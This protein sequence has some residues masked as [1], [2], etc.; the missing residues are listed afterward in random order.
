MVGALKEPF[1]IFILTDLLWGEREMGKK[2]CDLINR[3]IAITQKNE[4]FNFE[5]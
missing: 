5:Q 2:F 4:Q 3:T 1:L